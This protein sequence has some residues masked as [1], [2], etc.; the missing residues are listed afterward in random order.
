VFI[1]YTQNFIKLANVSNWP[2]THCDKKV[3]WLSM[4]KSTQQHTNNWEVGKL[5]IPMS[6]FYPVNVHPLKYGQ[7]YNILFS[8]KRYDVIVGNYP[9]WS[10]I[11]FVIMSTTSLGGCGAW[12]QCKHLYGWKH[13]MG[14]TQDCCHIV[15]FFKGPRFEFQPCHY[16]EGF[17][18]VFCIYGRSKPKEVKC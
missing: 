13:T 16:Y 18:Q 7:I 6:I 9:R 8:H 12:V 14:G 11:Y 17:S 2:T 4:F 10:Y 5:H 3:K 15:L 1:F